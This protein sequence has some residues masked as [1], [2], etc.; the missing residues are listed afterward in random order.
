[1]PSLSQRTRSGRAV[2]A[3]ARLRN[4]EEHSQTQPERT[5]RENAR[6]A[7]LFVPEQV[8]IDEVGSAAGEEEI[9]AGGEEIAAGEEEFAAGEVAG[10]TVGEDAVE[11]AVAGM[12]V[13]AAG[14][15]EVPNAG[16][17]VRWGDLVGINTIREEVNTAHCRITTWQKN[18]FELPR[19]AGVSKEVLEEA[20]RLIK[21]FMRKPRLNRLPYRL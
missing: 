7:E 10:Q 13:A 3:P 20:T 9:A 15:G 4:E 6:T 5:L 17:R 14:E 11:D 16:A 12:C 2:I 21:H 8:E 19:N 1:M 18:F